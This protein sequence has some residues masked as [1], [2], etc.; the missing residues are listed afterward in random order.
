MQGQRIR[1]LVEELQ[2]EGRYEVQWDGRDGQ[3]VDGQIA[4][5]IQG[6]ASQHQ[7]AANRAATRSSR[8][9]VRAICGMVT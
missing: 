5:K 4:Q 7:P 2:V 1:V 8:A 6:T 9:P 3:D